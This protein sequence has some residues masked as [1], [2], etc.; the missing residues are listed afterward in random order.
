MTVRLTS[1]YAA[2]L[3]THNPT[4]WWRLGDVGLTAVDKQ[5]NN[6][7]TYVNGVTRGAEGAILGDAD[8]AADF[9]GS[10]DYVNLGQMDSI[11][12]RRATF[13]CW[14]RA[15]AWASAFPRL[16]SRASGTSVVET[17]WQLSVTDTRRLR[18]TSSSTVT[19]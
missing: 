11:S 3:T 1:K 8:T 18:F 6:D 14:A 12:G 2:K 19:P 7:G 16:I 13:G 9:G 4:Y 10:N 15:D 5:G 17:R